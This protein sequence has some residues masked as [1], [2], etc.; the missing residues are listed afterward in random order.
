MLELPWIEVLFVKVSF[1]DLNMF[2]PSSLH[3]C[4]H[5]FFQSD[6]W[7]PTCFINLCIHAFDISL[8]YISKRFCI[9]YCSTSQFEN[10]FSKPK[11]L[12][13]SKKKPI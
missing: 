2:Y 8:L 11:Q 5:T 12:E 13:L 6:I 9:S 3:S 7:Q 1:A 4:Q 10:N